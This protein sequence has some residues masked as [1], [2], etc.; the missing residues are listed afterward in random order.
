MEDETLEKKDVVL[1]PCG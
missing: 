1:S